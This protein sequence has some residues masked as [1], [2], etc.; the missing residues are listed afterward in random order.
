MIV[1][2]SPELPVT[3]SLIAQRI[4][5]HMNLNCSGG[6]TIVTHSFS[7]VTRLERTTNSSQELWQ[8]SNLLDSILNFTCNSNSCLH[9][10]LHCTALVKHKDTLLMLREGSNDALL[11]KSQ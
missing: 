8:I 10:V 11:A 2:I 5:S 3:V 9:A 4:K 1:K 6:W 7:Y